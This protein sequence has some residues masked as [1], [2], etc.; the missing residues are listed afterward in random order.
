M[1]HAIDLSTGQAAVFVTG[2]PAWHRLGRVIEQAAN[3]QDAIKLAGLDWDVE[4]WPI[5]AFNPDNATIEAGCP[6]K[7]ANV[8]TDTRRTLGIVTTSYT[9]FQNR[10]AF[11][12]MDALVGDKLAMYE[13]AGA[14]DD[15]K[16]VWMLARIP[17]EYR[18]GSEDLIQ[19]Y[20]L[21]TNSHDGSQAL[22]MIPTSVRVVCQNTLNLALSQSSAGEGL[23]V[24]H[25]GSLQE[26]VREARQNFGVITARFDQFDEELHALLDRQM[27]GADVAG[28]FN[29]LMPAPAE[30]SDRSRK[31]RDEIIGKW[32]ENFDNP[33]Q[34]LPGI[35]GTAWAA[36][37]SV[38]EW[39]DHQ[40]P[41]SGKTEH[42]KANSRLKSIWFGSANRVKQ[43]AYAAALELARS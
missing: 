4:Q 42:E 9:V 3:S 33:R 16:R 39:A 18:V 35:H 1:A 38:S 25:Y 13:T 40:K 24:Y 28:Y 11:D 27:N 14:I 34:R 7:V 30:S 20:V 31:F 32:T 37:N 19:P 29:E 26:R 21:L 12:F 17:K 23:T 15:G 8:R 41:A 2:K 43:D 6:G 5:R 22:R 10:E 36:F